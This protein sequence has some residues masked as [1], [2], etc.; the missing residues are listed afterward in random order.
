MIAWVVVYFTQRIK[1]LGVGKR[2]KKK[3][4]KVVC[5]SF[6]I[7]ETDRRSQKNDTDFIFIR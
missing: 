3:L 1:M 7:S 2:K 4:A 6:I 5:V